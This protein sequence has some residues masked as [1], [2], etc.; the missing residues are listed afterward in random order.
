MFIDEA[1]IY[2]K[3]GDG[4]NGCISFRREKYIPRGG[5]DGGDGGD[6]G[7]VIFEADASIDT[8][9]DFRGQHH[10]RA[11]RGGD[12]QGSNCSGKAGDDLVVKVPVG[13]MVFDTRIDLMIKDLTFDGQRVCVA[14]AG[15]GGKGNQ[16]FAT[17]T[18]QVPRKAEMGTRG[19]ERYLKLELKLIGDVGLAGLPN[20][21]KS[22]LLSRISAARP[23]VAD[24]PFTTL[25]PNLGII[26]LSNYRRF[27]MADIPGLIEGASEG[28]GLGNDFLKHIERNKI[29]LHLVDVAPLDNSDP[30]ENYNV[31]R[32]ELQKHSPTLAA[33]PEIVVATKNDMDEDNILLEDFSKRLGKQVFGISSV[34]GKGLPELLESIWRE[35]DKEKAR[36]KVLEDEQDQAAIDF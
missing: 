18:D 31:I 1:E 32:N 3:A 5:P 28:L 24:Y 9:M 35:L 22:T 15:F 16:H 23:K 30:V 13:T 11:E 4:G 7:N 8:L 20:A 14:E 27:V 25:V 26:E 17:A 21:G 2:V 33:K 36:L 29:I 19:K 34:T 10:W 12:G 6:G